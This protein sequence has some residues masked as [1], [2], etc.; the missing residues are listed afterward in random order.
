MIYSPLLSADE[1]Y[2]F[3]SAKLISELNKAGSF[4]FKMP[5][6]NVAYGKLNKLATIVKVTSS[7]NT[8]YVLKDNEKTSTT[9]SASIPTTV[10]YKTAS[11]NPDSREITLSDPLNEEGSSSSAICN[12]YRDYPYFYGDRKD[13]S[14]DSR[15]YRIST[16]TATKSTGMVTFYMYS[17]TY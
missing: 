11:I 15:V 4:Q 12:N 1:G 7:D 14:T 3:L 6:N 9:A 16:V 13:G 2:T 17:Y 10:L 8:V 5:S